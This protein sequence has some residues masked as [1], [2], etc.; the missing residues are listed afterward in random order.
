MAML[1]LRRRL[2]LVLRP[3][4]LVVALCLF[5]LSPA[6]AI[7]IQRVVSDKGIEAWLVEDHRVPVVSLQMAFRG[8]TATD[9]VGKEGLSQMVAALLDEGAG[10][11]ES[12]AFQRRLEDYAIRLGFSA[13]TD[14]F[15]ANFTTLTEHRAVAFDML[16]LALIAPRFD[17][18][19][20]ERVASQMLSAIKA[21]AEN[22]RR[23]GTEL[24]YRVMYPDH[25]YG[26]PAQGTARSVGRI[27]K[28][29]LET[30]VR[31]RFGRDRMFV[32]VVGDITAADLR[33]LLDI[34]FSGLPAKTEP[35]AVPKV[36]AAAKGDVYVVQKNIPQSV[37]TFG[38]GGIA[39]QDPDYYVAYVL[40]NIL[41][42]GGLTSRLMEEARD[43]RG[44]VYSIYS[45][46][47]PYDDS[48]V[49]SGGA[50][51]RN[52]RVA[53]TIEIVRKE[54]ARL[55]DE[56]VTADEL[57]DAKTFLTGSFLTQISSSG[58]MASLLLGIQ[59]EELGIDY[60]DQ[61]NK[62]IESVTADDIRRVAQRLLEPGKLSFVVVGAPQGIE[63][64]AQAPED[65]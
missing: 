63:P 56:G 61:R 31:Q 60:I 49:I 28:H 39:R 38:H 2:V 3:V 19:P 22:P 11:L 7:D 4:A 13:A 57:A 23:I 24:W 10:N 5:G 45:S 47:V 6:L 51:T 17:Q 62:Y 15:G 64:T 42:G 52:E 58:R 16:R 33:P 18:G 8:G 20:R 14:S 50:A 35:I 27:E 9:P 44:L 54:W 55:R 30:Y 43:K 26:R 1:V 34:A 48:A 29:D 25:P 12:Q 41:G 59:L 53:D 65:D 32:A 46:L 21:G 37:V 40:N 36:A